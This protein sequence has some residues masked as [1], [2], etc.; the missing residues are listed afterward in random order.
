MAAIGNKV[1]KEESRGDI[2][3]VK[4]DSLEDTQKVLS[5]SLVILVNGM[6]E[7]KDDARK[8]ALDS[9]KEASDSRK[10]TSELKYVM[11]QLMNNN[12]NNNNNK[13]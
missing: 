6:K 1:A 8:E 12:N 11:R 13:Q 2:I 5:D 3:A 4:I 10:E 9:R 7:R